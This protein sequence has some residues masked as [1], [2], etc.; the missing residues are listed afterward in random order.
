MNEKLKKHI[1]KRLEDSRPL[2]DSEI[3]AIV[4]CEI[5][6]YQQGVEYRNERCEEYVPEEFEKRT[7]GLDKKCTLSKEGCSSR[8]L[9]A[10]YLKRAY[11]ITLE[12][13]DRMLKAQGGKCAICSCEL[14]GRNC[15]VDHN[16]ET[17]EVRGLLCHSCNVGLGMFRD[18][19]GRFLKAS[20]YLK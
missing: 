19:R 5:T 6:D 1:K 14:K 8:N 11:N 20:E 17:G 12:E 7:H 10:D 3:D 16:H 4:Y 2:S 15:H 18:D 9:W 13:Y